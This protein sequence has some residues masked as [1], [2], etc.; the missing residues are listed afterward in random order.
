MKTE[1][2]TSSDNHIKKH[3]ELLQGLTINKK[4][5]IIGI[6]DHV[7]Y[8][9]IDDDIFDFHFEW[10]VKGNKIHTE[11]I[12]PE[13][14]ASVTL[15]SGLVTIIFNTGRKPLQFTKNGKI[16]NPVEHDPVTET[17]P[18]KETIIDEEPI[19]EPIIDEESPIEEPINDDFET[20]HS[21]PVVTS[22]K[23]D[24]KL[25]QGL[26]LEKNPTF[27]QRDLFDSDGFCYAHYSNDGIVHFEN[28]NGDYPKHGK[29]HHPEKE[30]I[31]IEKPND[32][33]KTIK[34]TFDDGKIGYYLGSQRK[35]DKP[36]ENRLNYPPR[37][38]DVDFILKQYFKGRLALRDSTPSF[39]IDGEWVNY[40]QSHHLRI[41]L[42]ESDEVI[43][44]VYKAILSEEQQKKYNYQIPKSE[45]PDIL[46]MLFNQDHQDTFLEWVHS[47]PWDGID[48][49]SSLHKA[50]GL[51]STPYNE[52]P[53]CSNDDDDFY[54]RT[55]VHMIIVGS[56]QRHI[57]PFIQ[58]YIPVLIGSQG[59]GKSST[60]RALG[61]CFNDP[62]K[63]WY[64]GHAGTVNPDNN[65]REFFRPQIGK[66]IVELAEIDH[67]LTHDKTGLIKAFL[68]KPFAEYNEKHEKTMTKKNLT[69]FITGT[70]NF[71]QF[72]IDNSGNRRFA[73]V[74][75]NQQNDTPDRESLK[76]T[77]LFDYVNAPLYLRDHPDY[78]QQL[79]AQA[80]QK[81]IEDGEE[82]DFYIDRSNPDDIFTKVQKRMN[83]LSMREPQYMDLL[84]AYMRKQ[85]ENNYSK[86]CSWADIQRDFSLENEKIIDKFQL[87][88]LFKSFK[89]HP[90]KFG[91]SEYGSQRL[92]NDKVIKG[93]KLIDENRAENFTKNYSEIS[94]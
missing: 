84:V 29:K 87:K 82:Y 19:D 94:D 45:F 33:D 31:S 13:Q 66:A 10:F 52:E 67:L 17:T 34:V 2:V 12:H 70:T 40:T 4:L 5:R 57:K 7:D 22:S 43:R 18:I 80:Y 79:Y 42:T 46:S 30:I 51:T 54:C 72:L 16:K 58:E 76:E 35:I 60:L 32:I 93:F 86:V 14:I 55:I 24:G 25:G 27:N 77:N 75:M 9:F 69:A 91:F 20:A 44:E 1:I 41:L 85:C 23:L 47:V 28:W 53:I 26:R 65:G 68:D 92:T 89:E 11:T 38:I 56:I 64:F 21:K 61:G 49:L 15:S 36:D 8:G 62:T 48:R 83:N 73:I 6:N 81:Y 78:V 39:N 90:N 63:G 3:L 37:R 59:C 50:I 71:G 88:T 74:Y